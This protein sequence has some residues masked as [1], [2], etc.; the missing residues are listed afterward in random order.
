LPNI[1]SHTCRRTFYCT[2]PYKL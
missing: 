1:L 2:M